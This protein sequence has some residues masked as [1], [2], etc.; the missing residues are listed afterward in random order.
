MKKLVFLSIFFFGIS[1][2]PVFAGDADVPYTA[3]SINKG[4][5]L[6]MT[7]CTECHGRNGKAQVEAVS[8]ATD[9]TDPAGYRNGSSDAAIYKSIKEGAGTG[10]PPFGSVLK[11]EA[12]IG[13]LRNF[14]YSLWPEAR[15]PP[16]AK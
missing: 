16:V 9:L 13:N 1:A 10:M 6:Y 3:E 8:D 2:A 7:L 15:R 4:R 14:I 5:G 11:T 12:D